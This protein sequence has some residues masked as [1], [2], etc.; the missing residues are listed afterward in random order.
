M[1][2]YEM[3]KQLENNGVIELEFIPKE[4]IQVVDDRTL[5]IEEGLRTIQQKQE[6]IEIKLEATSE[7]LEKLQCNADKL[8]YA[9]AFS[10]GVIAGIVDAF[11]VGEWDFT[12]AKAQSNKKI[13]DKV[14][15][16]AKKQ[17]Y[18]G[19]RL[20]GAV[21][22]LEDE[23]KLLG[24]NDYHGTGSSA[25]THHLDD[26]C[27]HPTLIGLL[28]CLI[29]EFTREAV[30]YNS[31]G[32]KHVVSLPIG[33]DDKGYLTGETVETKLFA[34]TVN[35]CLNVARNWKGHIYSDMAGSNATA[36]AGMGIPGPLMSL[37]KE[38]AALPV[39]KDSDLPKQLKQAYTKGIGSQKGQ[40]D[41]GW[42]NALFEGDAV[43]KMDLRTEKAVSSILGKQSIP[44]L[45]NGI[46]VYSFYFLRRFI[47]ENRAKKKWQSVDF[48]QCLGVKNK[49]TL[50]RMFFVASGTFTAFDIID[51]SVHTLFSKKDFV[52][53][54]N[55]V[56]IGAFAVT[57]GAEMS[58]GVKRGRL[59]GNQRKLYEEL[60]GLTC[61]QIYFKCADNLLKFT[62][63][64]ELSEQLRMSMSRDIEL[65]EAEDT[66]GETKMDKAEL[67]TKVDNSIAK[68]E[69]LCSTEKMG[70]K[71][72]PFWKRENELQTQLE[73]VKTLQDMVSFFQS[74]MI[75][76]LKCTIEL[77]E[78]QKKLK[79]RTNFLCMLAL[80]EAV[81]IAAL[82]II[83]L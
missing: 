23:Y 57:L 78:S 32:E 63:V 79:T 16:F 34:G 54:L 13:N 22:F 69:Q 20:N 14:D 73:N 1:E 75:D 31:N 19:N 35:W 36:G 8:D 39:V 65:A 55:F 21:R 82:V 60:N 28:C 62:E 68:A 49:A 26:W 64:V 27:H 15:R 9:V 45:L 67:M 59:L 83:V 70:K 58:F 12:T 46:L 17:G 81:A 48:G 25:K 24:D 33:V 43:S 71:R 80:V 37:L 74:D 11:L 41:L 53:R 5:K 42:V 76:L 72:K 3:I 66:K 47:E 50:L 40:L 51:A 61:A 6:E 77:N 4:E 52:L 2:K 56:G 7:E 38:L 30:Y 29:R 44:V 18:K 10:S